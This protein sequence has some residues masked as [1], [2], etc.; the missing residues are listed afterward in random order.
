MRFPAPVT[1]FVLAGGRSTRMGQDK[2]LLPW[3]GATLLDLT[4]NKLRSVCKTVYICSDRLDLRSAAPVLPDVRVMLDGIASGPIGPMGGLLAALEQTKTDWNLFLPVDMPLLPVALLQNMLLLTE[5][6]ASL[7]IVPTLYDKPQPLCAAYHRALL[8]GLRQAA[9][10]GQW[11]ITTALKIA[12]S[13][14]T[15]HWMEC[16]GAEADRWFLNLN[17]PQD[18]AQLD[19]K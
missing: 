6:S 17:K 13:T 18:C 11:R 8:P 10:G 3:H 5:G 14:N 15:V 1:G 12:A 19:E 4:L 9:Q 2:V 7:A 16:A